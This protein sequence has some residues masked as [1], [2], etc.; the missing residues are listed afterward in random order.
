MAKVSTNISM[1]ADI[2][3]KAQKL[4]SQFGLDLTTAI[5]IFLRQS[6]REQRIPFEITMNVPNSETAKA[7]EEV[8][9]MERNPSTYKG[10]TDVDE[11]MKDLL[12]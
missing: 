5:N 11:M 1:D 10:Y 9:E 12:K 3:K 7:L 6:I 4:F 8:K 2:K